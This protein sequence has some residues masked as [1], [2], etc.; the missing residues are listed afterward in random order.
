MEKDD[1]PRSDAVTMRT[2]DPVVVSPPAYTE[3]PKS[4]NDDD[5]ASSMADCD[6]ITIPEYAEDGPDVEHPFAFP[7]GELPPYTAITHIDRPLA[8]PQIQPKPTASFLQ[9]YPPVLL[10][11]GIPASTWRDFLATLSSFLN[12]NAGK[13]AVRHATKIVQDY[14][15]I[16]V[17][18]G[19]DLVS[20]TESHL[21]DM[22]ES[23]QKGNPLAIVGSA[24]NWQIGVATHVIGK[25]LQVPAALTQKPQSP[26]ERAEVYVGAANK[27]W[28]HARALHAVL[29]S[30]AELAEYVKTS[31]AGFFGALEEGKAI[32]PAA[33]LNALRPW[34]GELNIDEDAVVASGDEASRPVEMVRSES[35]SSRAFQKGKSKVSSPPVKATTLQIGIKT[36]WIVLVQGADE[37]KVTEMFGRQALG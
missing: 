29:V 10:G 28:F 36:L 7:T 15:D 35:S 6:S 9:A 37:A 17:T 11:Y 12:A 18:L 26:R 30:T 20:H 4:D 21:R 27:K 5:T 23:L 13:N 16:H 33:Q 3:H 25:V 31:G 14:S 34:L 2:Q 22:G 24:L 1:V 19:K 8:V 32:T